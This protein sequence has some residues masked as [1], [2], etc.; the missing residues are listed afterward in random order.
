MA[1]LDDLPEDALA[2][3]LQAAKRDDATGELAGRALDA[4]R[5]LL[6]ALDTERAGR[7][8]FFKR[9][10]ADVAVFLEGLYRAIRD[11]LPSDVALVQLRAGLGSEDR[12][13]L[14]IAL[15]DSDAINKRRGPR[16]AAMTV[17]GRIVG[18]LTQHTLG[19]A[20]LDEVGNPKTVSVNPVRALVD[21][22]PTARLD[23]DVGAAR[24]VAENWASLGTR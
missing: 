2:Q 22:N 9:R 6:D 7:E 14:E 15:L 11:G 3:L 24:L 1:T 17:A 5:A 4:V 23:A 12:T 20:A 8:A 10:L 18:R 16:E 21:A 19:A 13:I